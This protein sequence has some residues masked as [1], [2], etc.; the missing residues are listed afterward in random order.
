MDVESNEIKIIEEDK[1][2]DN[3]RLEELN[4]EI[5]SIL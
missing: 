5:E 4:K 2:E 1:K 3:T